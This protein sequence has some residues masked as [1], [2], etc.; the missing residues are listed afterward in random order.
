MSAVTYKPILVQMMSYLDDEEY[1]RD[2]A[3]SQAQLGALTENLVMKWFNFE[4]HKVPEPLE[5]HD[6]NLLICSNTI[7]YWKK[8]ATIPPILCQIVLLHGTS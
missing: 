1:E 4:V 3:F 2:S 6:L 5:G 7:K 8:V